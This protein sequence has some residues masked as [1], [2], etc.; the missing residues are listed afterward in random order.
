[1]KATVIEDLSGDTDCDYRSVQVVETLRLW[2]K[3]KRSSFSCNIFLQNGI[4]DFFTSG[5]K[6]GCFS[7]GSEKG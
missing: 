6:L 2:K 4:F 3:S 1:M 5:F 7:S